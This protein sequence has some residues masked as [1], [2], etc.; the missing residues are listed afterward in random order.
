[1]TLGSAM[2]VTG[3]RL[4]LWASPGRVIATPVAGPVPDEANLV[5][6]RELSSVMALGGL[7]VWHPIDHV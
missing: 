4:N 5:A 3:V 2:A 1:M 6:L 7:S